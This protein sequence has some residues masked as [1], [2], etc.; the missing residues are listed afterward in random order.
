MRTHLA[1]SASAIV[2]LLNSCG[3]LPAPSSSKYV[4][5]TLAGHIWSRSGSAKPLFTVKRL[6]NNPS[7]LYLQAY[8][9]RP[10]GSSAAPIKRV[11]RGGM[12]SRID[13]EGATGIGWR[14]N[15]RYTYRLDV[16]SDP[17]YT[18]K[19]DSLSQQAICVV[20]PF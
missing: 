6:S 12:D 16:Y 19:I 3:T 4:K 10:D 9:P 13:F 14:A 11:A 2:I 8:L 15:R 7:P 18:V 20:P 17:K 1:L 5:A